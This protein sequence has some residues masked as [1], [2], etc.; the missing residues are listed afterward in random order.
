[1][2]AGIVY[3]L[4]TKW[5]MIFIVTFM[6]LFSPFTLIT[7]YCRQ[8]AVCFL[9][10]E[11]QKNA[12]YGPTECWSGEIVHQR[13]EDTVEIGEDNRSV[14]SQICLT[15]VRAFA[16]PDLQYPNSDPRGGAW[17]EADDEDHSNDENKLHSPLDFARGVHRL[18]FQ[19]PC[20]AS[21]AE[22]NND[23]GHAELNHVERVV[24]V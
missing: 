18:V 5:C 12:L 10:S 4:F 9:P 7:C 11:F 13:I 15:E 16:V 14:K 6:L 22:D 8:N 24:P 2:K 3:T 17:K 23:R 1:M 19:L 20:N 21:R